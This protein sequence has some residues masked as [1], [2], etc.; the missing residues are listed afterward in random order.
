MWNDKAVWC[1]IGAKVPALHSA[2]V[3]YV[4]CIYV[5][6]FLKSFQT[7]GGKWEVNSEL[8]ATQSE[9]NEKRNTR[10]ET[11]PLHVGAG[12]ERRADNCS[13]SSAGLLHSHQRMRAL[14]IPQKHMLNVSA[15]IVIILSLSQVVAPVLTHATSWQATLASTLS[16]GSP[17]WLGAAFWHPDLCAGSWH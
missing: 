14:S 7:D 8:L 1:W 13:I 2:A 16:F 10:S 9:I 4:C 15:M 17:D 6:L 5:I 12:S 11:K 3:I